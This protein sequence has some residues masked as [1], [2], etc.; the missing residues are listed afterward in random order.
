MRART[1]GL[2][3]LASALLTTASAQASVGDGY[4]GRGTA[5]SQVSAATDYNDVLAGRP[6]ALGI[7]RARAQGFVPSP[8]LQTYV[9]GVLARSSGLWSYF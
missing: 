7:M 9:Q 4:P 5:I 2:I 6:L 1:F 8:Q 3:A